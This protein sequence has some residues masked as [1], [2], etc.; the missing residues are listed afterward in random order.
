VSEKRGQL[1]RVVFGKEVLAICKIG[2]L[3]TSKV[4]WDFAHPI[5]SS[6]TSKVSRTLLKS[7]KSLF[8]QPNYIYRLDG[9]KTPKLIQT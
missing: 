7:L 2:T 4:A 6:Y 9:P 8:A 1:L 5:V 3:E